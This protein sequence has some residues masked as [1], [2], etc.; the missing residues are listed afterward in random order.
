M[1]LDYDQSQRNITENEILNTFNIQLI[2]LLI[3]TAE[4]NFTFTP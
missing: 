3:I 1:L 4:Q 2:Y